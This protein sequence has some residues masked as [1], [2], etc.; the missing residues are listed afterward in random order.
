MTDYGVNTLFL[1]WATV[2]IAL[3]KGENECNYCS[4][5]S[6]LHWAIRPHRTGLYTC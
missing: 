4:I 5:T 2:M 3:R 1:Y 6:L